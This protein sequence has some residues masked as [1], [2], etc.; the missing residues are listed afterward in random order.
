MKNLSSFKKKMAAMYIFALAFTAAIF[1]IP[2]GTL[3]FYE[4]WV[5]L[6][7]LFIPMFFL[8]GYFLKKDPAILERRM[9]YKERV[10]TQKILI[11]IA[12]II[13]LIA[14]LIPGF[15]HR[16]GWS[17][18]PFEIVITADVIIFLSYL[19]FFLVLKENS[20]AS[21]VIEVTKD[22]K[23]IS[24]GPY[25]IVRHPMYVAITGMMIAMPIALGSLWAMIPFLLVIPVII[26]RILNE[27]KV[28]KDEL[29]GYKEYCHKTRFR[30]IPYIW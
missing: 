7:V 25:A 16:Y 10:K 1:F 14:F 9:N 21:R 12:D 15:D 11:T 17:N 13:F 24:T 3:D 6:G 2:A 27:E 28:L 30:L 18:I 5:F 19:L 29:K 26:L 8:L 4:V 20:Y 22:Q 23:V